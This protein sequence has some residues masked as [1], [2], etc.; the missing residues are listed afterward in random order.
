MQLR[1]EGWLYGVEWEQ[2]P[3]PISPGAVALGA[4]M[5]AWPVFDPPWPF[6]EPGGQEWEHEHGRQRCEADPGRRGVR[7]LASPP[8]RC[9]ITMG[10]AGEA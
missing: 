3:V 1:V 2:A 8:V 10:D 7:H 6:E 9:R 4:D 5:F